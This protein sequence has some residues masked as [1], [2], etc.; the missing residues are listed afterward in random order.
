[1]IT[2][3]G[4]ARPESDTTTLTTDVV[5]KTLS[6]QRRRYVLH[7]LKQQD[8][9]GSVPIRA[10]S[11]Q[12]AAWENGVDRTAV[13][14]KQRKRIYTALHQTHLPK[15]D[16][17][18][19]VEYDRNRGTVSMANSMDQ[20]D[21]YFELTSADDMP[22]SHLYLGLG[23]VSAALVVCAALSIWP[24]ALFSGYTY[25]LATAGLFAAVAGYHTYRD[26]RQF[27]GA[28][29]AP[30]ELDIPLELH[31]TDADASTNEPR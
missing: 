9:N 19:I 18:G 24:F 23:S 20:F 25:A 11:E 22:W 5:F 12:L 13:N 7:Y 30:P 16:Q 27:I 28:S 14:P 15:M 6:N 10:L 2:Q 29:R 26:R 1:M 31:A 17:L 3:G 8:S 4:R 21:I